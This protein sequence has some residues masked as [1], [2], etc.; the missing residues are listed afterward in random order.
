MTDQSFTGRL[1]V[2]VNGLVVRDRSLLLIKLKSPTGPEPFWMPPGGGVDYGEHLE[3]AVAR[4]MA[5]EAGIKVKVGNLRYVSEY[6]KLPWHAVEFYFDCMPLEDGFG[7]GSD[8]ELADHE[9]MLKD[10]RFVPF[11]KLSEYNIAPLY[12]KERFVRDYLEDRQGT[13]YVRSEQPNPERN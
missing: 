8:P 7:L 11:D 13:V 6:V 2:R 5:E 12:L 1:R 4:E 9:Q 10:I 3:D